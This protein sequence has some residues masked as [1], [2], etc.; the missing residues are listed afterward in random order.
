MATITRSPRREARR[1][2]HALETPSSPRQHR[3]GYAY[4]FLSVFL[5]GSAFHLIKA[6]LSSCPALTAVPIISYSAALGVILAGAVSRVVGWRSGPFHAVTPLSI[7]RELR[8]YWRLLLPATI[9]GM[10]GGWLTLLT[11]SMYS[12]SLTA[13]LANQVL[14]FLIVIGV[15]LGDRLSLRESMCIVLVVVGAFMFAY[16]G[17]AVAW[18]ALGLML[19]ACALTATKQVLVK[20]AVTRGSLWKLV[21]AQQILMGTWALLLSIGTGGPVPPLPGALGLLVTAGVVGSFVGMGMLYAGYRQVGIAR[22]APINAMRPLMVLVIGLGLGAS[23]PSSVQAAGG[24]L[25]LG[26]SVLLAA[27]RRMGGNAS[28][29]A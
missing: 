10:L 26:G 17:Q 28:G 7:W 13:F 18:M 27:G 16:T 12:A 11:V 29:I 20:E 8:A 5:N 25:V 21:A 14:V 22:G 15:A 2:A 9:S 6:G 24:I 19:I 3:T 1:T 23:L 4:L